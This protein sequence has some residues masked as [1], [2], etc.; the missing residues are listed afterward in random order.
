MGELPGDDWMGMWTRAFFLFFV[1]FGI[2]WGG[3]LGRYF[4]VPVG[5]GWT[6]GRMNVQHLPDV[7]GWRWELGESRG[8]WGN[9][10]FGLGQVFGR[11]TPG[12]QGGEWGRQEASDDWMKR[13]RST[14]CRK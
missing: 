7:R 4:G 2:L 12:P 9:G 5:Q 13:R 3:G 10:D 11:G 1:N 6:G 8:C 14:G